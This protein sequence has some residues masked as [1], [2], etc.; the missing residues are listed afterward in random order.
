[1]TTDEAIE[2]IAPAIQPELPAWMD[3]GAGSG[4]FTE[5]L[6]HILGPPGTV[7]AVDNDPAAVARL[8]SRVERL[9]AGV[10]SV[11]AVPGDIEDLA[12]IP[13]LEGRRFHGAL[14]ANVLHFFRAP[15]RILGEVGS[16]LASGGRAVVVEYGGVAAN[17]WVPHPISTEE[18]Q[19]CA[20]SAGFRS[21]TIVA[22]RPS[23]FRGRLYCAVLARGGGGHGRSAVTGG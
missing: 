21:T 23:R 17:R 12:A 22:E 15:A 14:L 1:M 13:A 8:R 11:E 6:A 10:A 19:R 3:L 18:L 9:S 2:F 7:V 5:A 4:T 16:R 20:D